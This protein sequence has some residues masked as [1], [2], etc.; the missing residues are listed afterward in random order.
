M[1]IKFST[2][3][4]NQL[5]K[6]DPFNRIFADCILKIYDGAIPSTADAAATG[7]LL[8]SITKSSGAVTVAGVAKQCYLNITKVDTGSTLTPTIDGSAHTFT[9]GA[10]ADL[11]YSVADLALQIEAYYPQLRCFGVAATSGDGALVFQAKVPGVTFTCTI[12]GSG[13]GTTGN[14]CTHD[15]L[16]DGTVV[17][18]AAGNAL[19]FGTV[20]AGVISKNAD[21]WSGTNA[22][23]GTA[24]YFR[25]VQIADDGTLVTVTQPRIQGSVGVSGSDL[26]VNS[27]DFASGATTTIDSGSITIPASA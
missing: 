14:A 22:A 8:C 3:L 26:I 10:G 1:T 15:A 17:V 18:N 13:A 19:K 23:D 4:R 5:L 25:I 20:S 24:S 11:A 2:A 7:T 12:A 21:T 16:I 6:G 27:T 9:A